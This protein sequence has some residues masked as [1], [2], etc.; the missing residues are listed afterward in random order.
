MRYIF[1]TIVIVLILPFSQ[2]QAEP[3]AA[4]S[5]QK[6]VL[7]AGGSKTGSANYSMEFSLGQT[8]SNQ[9]NSSGYT[10]NWGFWA[11]TS[12]GPE[13]CQGECGDANLDDVVNIS[14]IV[15]IINY[16]FVGGPEPLP[17]LACGDV[18]SDKDVNVS[19]A[20]W[21]INYVFEGGPAPSECS[22]GAPAWYN[23]DCCPFNI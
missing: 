16:V 22:P 7:S 11:S 14:D 20:V 10:G 18:N 19:D 3:Q 12:S 9:S 6:D 15:W 5:L 8:A 1:I 2:S 17:V 13:E 4:D 21:L 23:G